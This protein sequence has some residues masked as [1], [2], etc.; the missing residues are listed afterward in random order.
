LSSDNFLIETAGFIAAITKQKMALGW[1][2]TFQVTWIVGFMGGGFAYYII[3]LISP[4]PGNPYV[5]ELIDGVVEGVPPH[6]ARYENKS[7]ASSA[8][9]VDEEM[10]MKE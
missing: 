3:T 4:P 9:A 1:T 7:G 6:D 8:Q 5:T 2:R 10:G